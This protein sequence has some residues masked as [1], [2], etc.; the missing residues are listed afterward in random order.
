[1]LEAEGIA[2]KTFALDPARMN[3]VARIK[4]NSSKR[5]ILLMG[6]TDV[7]GVQRE[8]WTVDPFAAIRKDGFIYGRGATDDKDNLTAGLMVLLLLKR[9]NVVLDRDVILLA[10]AGEE[11]STNVGIDFMVREHWPEID[12]E[13]ALAEGWGGMERKGKVL[14]MG[15]STTE[16]IT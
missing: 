2:I 13:F 5:P 10:E 9:S 8:K 1:M 4:G 16:K 3:L 6:H 12:A 14:Y 11:S 15:V 7:V